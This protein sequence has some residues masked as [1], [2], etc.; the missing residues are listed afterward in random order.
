MVGRFLGRWDAALI[1]TLSAVGDMHSGSLIGAVLDGR[2]RITDR[3]ARGGVATVYRGVDLRLDRTIAAKVLDLRLFTASE[4]AG[5]LAEAIAADLRREA[6]TIARLSHPNVVAVYDHGTHA[7]H[8]Y[9]VMEYVPGRTLRQVLA[10]RQRLEPVAALELFE[11]VLAALAAAHRAG[12]VHRDMK[13]ENVLIGD[14]PVNDIVK[15]ADFGLARAVQA[16]AHQVTDGNLLATPGY[17]APELVRDG[18]SDVRSDVYSAGIM[19]FELL[20][21]RLPYQDDSPMAV[22]CQHVE[23][24]VPAPSTLVPDLPESL[25][26]LVL[27][28]TRRDPRARWQHA[29]AFLAGLR[30]ERDSLL[31]RVREP[32]PDRPDDAD[33]VPIGQLAEAVTERAARRVPK[34]VLV[35]ALGCLA[36]TGLVVVGSLWPPEPGPES[37]GAAQ[38]APS[39]SASP[40]PSRTRPSGP[41]H[42]RAV[43]RSPTPVRTPAVPPEPTTSRQPTPTPN[44]ST[45]PSEFA[46]Q[47]WYE[48]CS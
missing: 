41:V 14:G 35:A 19:L 26:E 22:A 6:K 12:V 17:V 32:Q 47:W 43:T 8:P 33:T 39:R 38:T 29:G 37:A 28:A 42:S 3:I 25:D 23:R 48:Y 9:L 45:C 27:R 30:A 46:D 20:T 4:L 44:P 7:G 16:S 36:V 2:Y 11:P 13:P 34:A 21:G 18:R 31:S 5:R 15:V 24:D 10:E 1:T 40:S